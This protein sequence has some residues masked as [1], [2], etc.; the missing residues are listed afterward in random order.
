MMA[1]SSTRVAPVPSYVA[2]AAR[3]A[4]PVAHPH[5]VAP[6]G[7]RDRRQVLDEC[8]TRAAAAVGL[9]DAQLVEEH[10]RSL[11]RMDGLD[12]ADEADR[13]GAVVRDE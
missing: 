5:A 2:S 13:H 6:D 11:V 12:P 10:L 8:P 9:R 3:F 7:P 4:S 1:G